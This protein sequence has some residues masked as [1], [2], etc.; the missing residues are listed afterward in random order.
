MSANELTA[1]TPG[2]DE[3]IGGAAASAWE[4]KR[5]LDEVLK[6]V[7]IGWGPGSLENVNFERGL[8]WAKNPYE[9]GEAGKTP[10]QI[11]PHAARLAKAL[12]A[13]LEHMGQGV[14][15]ACIKRAYEESETRRDRERKAHVQAPPGANTATG[16]AAGGPRAGGGPKMSDGKIQGSGEPAKAPARGIRQRVVDAAAEGAR[17]APVELAL[18]EGQRLLVAQLLRGFKGTRGERE[19]AKK[20]LLWF[21][22]QPVGQVAI[23]GAISGAAPL[24]AGL[25]GRDGPTVQAVSDEFAARAATI[26]TKEGIKLAARQLKPVLGLFSG[27]FNAAEPVGRPALS[28]GAAAPAEDL[29][30]AFATASARKPAAEAG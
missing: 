19:G 17:R 16:D 30:A 14:D 27:L 24:V 3:P 15:A 13:W 6:L 1:A 7:G 29:A 2:Y 28:L 4:I 23:A 21:F 10:Y 12:S 20:F 22:A 11:G 25:L 26:V 9:A 5:D 18:E 8:V